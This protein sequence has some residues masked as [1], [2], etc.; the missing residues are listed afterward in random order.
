MVAA[1]EQPGV[2]DTSASTGAGKPSSLL[3]LIF[4]R[5]HQNNA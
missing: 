4:Q 2:D 1:A 5:D 3:R